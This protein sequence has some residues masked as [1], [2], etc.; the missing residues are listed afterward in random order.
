LASLALPMFVNKETKEFDHQRLYDVTTV[1][2]KNLNKIIDINYYPIPQAEYSNRKNR[3]IGIGVQGLADT[4]ILLRMPFDSEA[5]KQLNKDIFETIYYAAL[6]ASCDLAQIHGPYDSYAGSPISQGILQ[7]DM[8]NVVPDSNRWDWDGLRA[9]I[10]VHGVR[11]SLVCAP[12]PTATTS[13]IL[14]NNEA[15][16][17]YTSN[18]YVRRTLAG[19]FVCVSRHLLTDLIDLGVWSPELKNKLIAANGSVQHIAE[20]PESLKQLYKTVWEISQKTIIDMAADRGAYIDQ[21]QS[22]NIHMTNVSSDKLTSMHFHAWKKGLKT[23]MYYLRTKAAT[24]AIKFTLKPELLQQEQ[25]LI[26]QQQQNN[27]D[28]KQQQQ[29]QQ[30]QQQAASTQN[31]AAVV[32]VSTVTVAAAPSSSAS[33]SI[34]SDSSW[35][36]NNPNLPVCIPNEEGVCEVCSS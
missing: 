5:A 9:K 7:F 12:M 1:V 27:Q 6:T 18:I 13:Q 20:I 23:G 14:G 24:D 22:L 36:K 15:F 35:V 26:K 28:K 2:T 21:S 16:E 34:D 29:Q 4:F 3:P 10:H 31:I 30:Q 25:Q 33:Q 11:N 19:E 17:P 32:S 8:W